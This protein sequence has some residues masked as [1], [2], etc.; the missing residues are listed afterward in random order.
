[1]IDEERKKNCGCGWK[2][3]LMNPSYHAQDERIE[4]SK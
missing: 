3:P 2:M 1:M 4:I